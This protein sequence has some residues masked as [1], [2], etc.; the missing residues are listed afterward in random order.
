MVYAGLFASPIVARYAGSSP[1]AVMNTTN[2]ITI[3][4]AIV[5]VC[6]IRAF[7]GKAFSIERSESFFPFLENQVYQNLS[8]NQ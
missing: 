8:E 4:A 7:R 3:A 2:P 5:L 6:G 1:F